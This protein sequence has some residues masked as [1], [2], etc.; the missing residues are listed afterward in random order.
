MSAAPVFFSSKE[1][2]RI[3]HVSLRQLQWWD[4]TGILSPQR[5][6]NKRKYQA[7][8]V[9]TAM[10]VRELLERKFSTYTARKVLKELKRRRPN[11]LPK[12]GWLLTNGERLELLEHGDVVLS[13]LEQRRSPLFVLISLGGL[14]QALAQGQARL[15]RFA[16]IDSRLAA[17]VNPATVEPERCAIRAAKPPQRMSFAEWSEKRA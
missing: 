2:S 5:V 4:E 16:Q 12:N 13:F 6:Q 8:E 11:G 17:R 7:E 9:F 3:S 14:A 15:R 1:T 10:L